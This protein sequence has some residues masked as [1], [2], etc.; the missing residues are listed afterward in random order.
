MVTCAFA[1]FFARHTGLWGMVVEL[2]ERQSTVSGLTN[3]VTLAGQ[4]TAGSSE[5][6][7]SQVFVPLNTR[8][9]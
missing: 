1:I 6:L 9:A 2:V 8:R 4:R 5:I 7:F 3:Q